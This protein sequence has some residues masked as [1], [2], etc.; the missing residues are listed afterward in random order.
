MNHNPAPIKVLL[1]DDHEVVR[2]VLR[3]L[4]MR[5]PRVRVLGE[6]STVEEA[7]REAR[8]LR[9]DVVLLDLRL[10]EES[11]V[12]ACRR[13]KAHA[14]ATRVLVLTAFAE[15][16]LFLQAVRAGVDGYVLKEI[17]GEA[18]HEALVQVAEGRPVLDSFAAG[19]LMKQLQSKARDASGEGERALSK[20]ER[21][22]VAAVAEGWTNKEI[23]TNLQLAEKTVKNYLSHVFEKLRVTRRS[24]VAALYARDPGR[25]GAGQGHSPLIH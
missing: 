11:G 22:L 23:A 10:K 2:S 7:V 25:F 20:Q 14:P 6:A 21:R 18:L 24:Q 19:R 1:V 13:I 5:F 16:A 17:N 9:P 8:R 4:L 3:V 15:E 12:E